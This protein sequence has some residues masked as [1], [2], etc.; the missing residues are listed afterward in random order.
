MN[1][2]AGFTY[3]GEKDTAMDAA[4]KTTPLHDAHLKLKAKMGA[5]AG[6][7]MP[8]YYEAGVMAEHHWT[9]GHAGLFD[10]SHMGQVMVTGAGAQAFFEKIT[11]SS[12]GAAPHGRAK[13]TVMTNAQGGIIDDLI[14]TKVKD[15]RY[16]AVVNAGCKDKDFAWM[17]QN[18]PA[19]VHMDIMDNRALIALQGP[20]AE[21]VLRDALHID[22]DGMP[23]MWFM[24]TAM[25]DGT[26]LFISRLG[27][28]GEDGFEI[29]VPAD[30]ADAVWTHFIKH[31]AVKPVGLAARDSLRLEMGYPLYGHDIDD[32]T[33]PVEAGLSWV[34]G[35]DNTGFT[36]AD[37]I[38]PQ[39]AKGTARQRVGIKLTERGVA[40][41]GA[42]IVANGAVVG[43]LTSGGPAP[44]L[45]NQCVG[46]GYV[47]VALAAPGTKLAVRVRGKDIA[48]EV[49]SL[50]FMKARTKSM[51]LAA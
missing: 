46:M 9:R 34:M 23:Y 27:Y 22:A 42:E 38:V 47:P 4:I 5:F 37:I 6:Y 15:D 51:K 21:G 41:E 10:V 13:Y 35:K 44:S 11:P 25:A 7:D 16:F 3:E 19:G 49:A 43:T 40:R 1:N 29:S 20:Q 17:K 50:P 39:L 26:P 36:G 12:F 14:V 33:S 30:M 2:T 32:S 31:G 45:E 48:A 28:T 24:E 18:L 8:L